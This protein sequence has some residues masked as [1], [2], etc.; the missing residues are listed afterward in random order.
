MSKQKI[1][2]IKNEE[3]FNPPQNTVTNNIL[4]A[5]QITFI[6]LK[7]LKV[8]N[9]SWWWVFSPTLIPLG[10]V[11]VILLVALFLTVVNEIFRV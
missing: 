7:L 6:I 11:F 3:L 10:I 4:P 1:K 8:I 5:L 9:W 2:D